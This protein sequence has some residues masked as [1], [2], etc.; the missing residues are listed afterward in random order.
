MEAGKTPSLSHPLG[1]CVAEK[2]KLVQE[3][4]GLE[5]S[6]AERPTVEGTACVHPSWCVFY[7]E[8]MH[9][10]P[11]KP[12]HTV[13]KGS[14]SPEGE[15]QSKSKLGGGIRLAWQMSVPTKPP[16]LRRVSHS[17]DFA[18]LTVKLRLLGPFPTLFC[19]FSASVASVWKTGKWASAG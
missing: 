7:Q 17:Q 10:S 1:L 15:G 6:G 16:C 14:K 11:D 2:G 18:D 4:P 12:F 3:S 19:F 13:P 9:S 5:C 8:L